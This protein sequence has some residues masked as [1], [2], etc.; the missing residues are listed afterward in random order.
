[1]KEICLIIWML[2]SLIFV[3]SI[4]GLILFIPKDSWQNQENVPSS[5]NM[6]GIKLINSI[7]K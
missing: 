1:M 3:L 5:W 7:V 2:I 6:I 4:V